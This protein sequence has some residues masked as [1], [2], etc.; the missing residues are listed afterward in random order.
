MQANP[1]PDGTVNSDPNPLHVTGKLWRDLRPTDE[2]GKQVRDLLIYCEHKTFMH[3]VT[4]VR[5]LTWEMMSDD[6]RH[7]APCSDE[8]AA[9]AIEATARWIIAELRMLPPC[10]YVQTFERWVA[11]RRDRPSMLDLAACPDFESWSTD[12]LEASREAFDF[13]ALAVEAAQER[14]RSVRIGRASASIE[15]YINVVR[16]IAAN[17]VAYEASVDSASYVACSIAERRRRLG[18]AVGELS[19]RSEVVR[20][21]VGWQLSNGM[22]EAGCAEGVRTFFAEFSDLLA[23]GARS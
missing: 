2:R 10:G 11:D 3:T 13:E 12:R 7:H 4:V 14:A 1:T 6:L 23:P 19:D 22:S 21:V 15:D 16:A 9:A 18:E 8:R 5:D 17:G 20:A